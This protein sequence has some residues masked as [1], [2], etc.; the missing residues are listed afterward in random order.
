MNYSEDKRVVLSL[1]AGGTNLNF[2]AVQS[3]RELIE[4]INIPANH[5]SLEK[6]LKDIIRGFREVQKKIE[7]KTSAISFCFPGPADY[8]NGIIGD[9]EN[10]PEFRGGVA[11][12]AM[13]E[14]EFQVPVFI[15]NDGDLFT[16]GESIAGLLPDINQKLKEAG[17]SK[18]YKNLLGIT[19][20][21]GFGGGIVSNGQLITGDNS[22]AAEINRM[23]NI[24]HPQTSI[25]DSCSIRAVKREYAIAAGLKQ[26]DT[27]EPF[28]IY[29]IA[30]GETPGNREAAI[31]SFKI[32]AEATAYALTNAITMV[33]G[34]VVIG[35]GLSGAHSLFLDLA[36]QKMN[37]K[38]TSLNNHQFP[39]LEIDVFNLE[40]EKGLQEFLADHSIEIDIPF[41]DKKQKYNP[42]KK[43]GVGV[44]RLGTGN[45]VSIGAYAFALAMLD[46]L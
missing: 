15:N 18:Q 45:A 30:V 37:T 24:L 14:N 26:E 39:H 31:T 7:Y 19:L 5:A 29:K 16:Y 33:D 4:T 8:E 34:L 3:N 17:S 10:L 22:A 28:E 32:L 13:L 40:N 41:S 1:D 36:V 35:G 23:Q 43:I 6:T 20:G 44:S 2:N 9:L 21:T 25:E 38:Y 11:L 46:E 12:K 42:E 27:P